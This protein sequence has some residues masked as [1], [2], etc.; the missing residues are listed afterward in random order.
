MLLFNRKVTIARTQ[1]TLCRSKSE[2]GAKPKVWVLMHSWDEPQLLT[3][4][5]SSARAQLKERETASFT[6][7]LIIFVDRCGDRSQAS[8]H[9]CK[10]MP[11]CVWLTPDNASICPPLGSAA[12][13]WT[14]L[15]YLKNHASPTEYFTFLDGDDVYGSDTV[16]SSIVNNFLLPH[17]PYFVW[18]VQS[19]RFSHQ[20]RD[21][22]DDTRNLLKRGNVHPA[23]ITW[24]FCHPRLFR[25]TLLRYLNDTH[26]KRDDGTWLQKA[27]DRPL[28][29]SAL[30]TA[31][32]EEVMFLGG[33]EP[34]ILYSETGKNGLV[35]FDPKVRKQDYERVMSETL[36]HGTGYVLHVIAAIY[37]RNN[38]SAFL[39]AFLASALPEDSVLQV[40]L[41]NN[42]PTREL[43]LIELARKLSNDIVT[44]S[45]TNIGSNLRGLSRFI[46]TTALLKTEFMDYVIFIDDDQIVHTS[47]IFEL[48]GQ[49]RRQAMV[50]WYGKCWNQHDHESYWQPLYGYKEVMSQHAEPRS[51]HYGGTG[52][53][54]IDT[55]IFTDER[56]LNI[57]PEYR[58]VEDLWLSYILHMNNWSLRRAFVH[59]SLDKELNAVGQ[60]VDL[61]LTKQ[62]MFSQLKRCKDSLP[63]HLDCES[64]P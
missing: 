9:M 37:D 49:R 43:A 56:V 63:L 31:G 36:S 16:L 14:M 5:I 54:I 45:V 38:T 64:G 58:F 17:R 20:C 32:N 42:E 52:L 23:D 12:A 26:F 3:R 41:A 18:G 13:K 6:M 35:R 59:V 40:H 15:S 27:T 48:W 61:K 29:Y 33:T 60:Y 22:N 34:H 55:M 2:S 21:L 57:P 30:A 39:Q 53:S 62:K 8:F 11:N 24:V 4:A 47:T 25:V 28:V 46:L 51:W 50:S 10:A 1:T 44:F 19:G 7:Q